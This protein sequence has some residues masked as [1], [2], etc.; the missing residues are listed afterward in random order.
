MSFG[1]AQSCYGHLED[2][3]RVQNVQWRAQGAG[4][5]FQNKK[6]MSKNFVLDYIQLLISG[7]QIGVDP[8]LSRAPP[9]ISTPYLLTATESVV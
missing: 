3:A 1:R 2:N 5:V 9:S 4:A 8:S 7:P 6:K